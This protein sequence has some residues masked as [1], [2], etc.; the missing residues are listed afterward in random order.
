VTVREAVPGDAE[1]IARV[2]VET[3][4]TAYRGIVPNAF[5]DEMDVA[6][7]ADRWREGF[8]ERRTTWVAESD[9]EVAEFVA[10]GPCRDDDASE[11]TA[12]LYAIYV[13]PDRW[14][15]GIGRSLHDTCVAALRRDGFEEASLWTLEA[16]PD[17][18]AFYERLG[19]APDGTTVQ[20]TFGDADL[21]IVRYRRA[22]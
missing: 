18:R 2:Q 19:W 8:A 4:R 14:R 10:F 12:E 7:R 22:L 5:L 11:R 15:R 17:A 3:W 13:L 21:P 20:H 6:E 1:A 9:G 16:I